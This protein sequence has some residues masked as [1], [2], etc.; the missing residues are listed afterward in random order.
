MFL[1]EKYKLPSAVLPHI[2]NEFTAM[3]SYHQTFLSKSVNEFL[4][5]FHLGEEGSNQLRL[6]IQQNSDVEN[7]FSDLNSE[8]KINKFARFTL[9][10][11][12]PIEYKPDRN[13][14]DTYQYVPILE[15]LKKLL[16]HDDIFSY[17]I[18]NHKSVDGKLLDFC[19][20]E[21][22]ERN[23]LFQNYQSA[24]QIMFFSMKLLLQIH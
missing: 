21:M 7:A 10:C 15:T 6:I 20:G 3:V 4:A 22:Y 5:N 16:S 23:G 17:V 19:D 1:R 18:N 13:K 9:N 2:V 24:L 11:V 8:Y 14:K 12:K